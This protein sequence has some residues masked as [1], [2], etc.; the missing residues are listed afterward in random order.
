MIVFDI[1]TCTI[2]PFTKFNEVEIINVQPHQTAGCAVCDVW[3]SCIGVTPVPFGTGTV[4]KDMS[5]FWTQ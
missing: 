3:F 5:D 1:E 2:H 4:I